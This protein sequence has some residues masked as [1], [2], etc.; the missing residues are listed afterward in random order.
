MGG[1]FFIAFRAVGIWEELALAS[2]GSPRLRRQIEGVIIG[3]C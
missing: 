3:K 1:V 2:D